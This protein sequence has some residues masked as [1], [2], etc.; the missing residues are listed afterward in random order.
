MTVDRS[1]FYRHPDGRPMTSQEQLV[2]LLEIGNLDY[3]AAAAIAGV[4]PTTILTYRKP[5]T[6]SR[7][8]SQ[9][10]LRPLEKAV[11]DKLTDIAGRAGYELK[12]RKVA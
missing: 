3:N 2:L 1:T 8:V 6:K 7:Q 10:I 11:F 5:S 12:P 4:S 9:A